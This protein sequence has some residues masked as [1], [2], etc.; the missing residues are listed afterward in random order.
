MDVG[1]ELNKEAPP[2]AGLYFA[3]IKLHGDCM[4][5]YIEIDFIGVETKKVVTPF[6]FVTW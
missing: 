3:A 4:T 6:L 2:S 5:D 1:D